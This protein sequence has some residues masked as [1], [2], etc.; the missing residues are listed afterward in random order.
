MGSDPGHD[1]SVLWARLLTQP[2]VI[3]I[4][5][6]IYSAISTIHDNTNNTSRWARR[7]KSKIITVVHRPASPHL[8]VIQVIKQVIK[9]V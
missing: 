3:I 2:G 5:I 8:G 7:N 9:Y 4:I 1:T 6:I